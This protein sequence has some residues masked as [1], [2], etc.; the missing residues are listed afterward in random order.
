MAV[1]PTTQATPRPV[2]FRLPSDIAGR[3]LQQV[4]VHPG[5]TRRELQDDLGL[6][7]ATTSRLI[8]RLEKAGLI[9]LGSSQDTGPGRPSAGLYVDGE[10]LLAVGAHVGKRDTRIV[11]TDLQGRVLAQDRLA[12]DVSTARADDALETV[13]WRMAHLAQQAPVPIQNAGVAFSADVHDDGTIT[14]PTYGWDNVPALTLTRAA[15]GRVAATSNFAPDVDVEVCTGVSAMAA[16]ELAHMDLRD[17]ESAALTRSALYVYAREV[18]SYA[19]IVHGGIHRPR[20]GHQN[21]LLSRFMRDSPLSAASAHD[22]TDPLS[23]SA[24]LAC[25]ADYGY[26]ASSLPELVRAARRDARLA[27]LLDHRADI[28][29]GVVD[30]AVQVI[31]PAAVVFAGE[32]FSAD[33]QRTRRIAGHVQ[34]APGSDYALKAYPANIDVIVEAA[35]M[36]ALHAPWQQP[37]GAL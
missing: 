1:P 37:L 3:C 7:Q 5:I 20:L 13:A 26:R 36:I 19:W 18:V 32:T 21:P 9:R 4:R 14:S 11:L 15:L 27:A 2:H 31:D 25:A 23:V 28:L 6:T 10:E 34:S 24:L 16:F 30:V 12:L 29:G 33:P 22:G 35:K 17:L 8:T